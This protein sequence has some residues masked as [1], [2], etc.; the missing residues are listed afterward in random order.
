[1]KEILCQLRIIVISF[2]GLLITKESS[3]EIDIANGIA[4]GIAN[5]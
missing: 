4:N 5:E 2:I 3:D 1:M